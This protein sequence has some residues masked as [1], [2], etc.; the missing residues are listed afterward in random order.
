METLGGRRTC[1]Q[2][3]N[4]R[5]SGRRF[6]RLAHGVDRVLGAPRKQVLTYHPRF[7]LLGQDHKF[8]HQ[9]EGDGFGARG[10]GR[11]GELGQINVKLGK[12][13]TN[14][15]DEFVRCLAIDGHVVIVFGA[16]DNPGVCF[17]FVE[18]AALD[19]EADLGDLLVEIAGA[20][21]GASNE[22]R[23]SGRGVVGVSLE[24]GTNIVA[25][26]E[27][28][29]FI[30]ND[31]FVRSDQTETAALVQNCGGVCIGTGEAEDIDLAVGGF[32]D[33]FEG[34]GVFCAEQKIGAMEENDAVLGCEAAGSLGGIGIGT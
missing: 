29:G 15:F 23:C 7:D 31:E 27:L 20:P 13:G 4:L 18:F 19:D 34:G 25:L 1:V 28:F 8:L 6:D 33:F 21:G 14:A 22:E 32:E 24:E 3:R 2:K 16:A 9:F 17:G 5:T 30:E 10:D 26:D 12:I 11:K